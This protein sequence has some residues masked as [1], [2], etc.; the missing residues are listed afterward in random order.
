MMDTCIR[1]NREKSIYCFKLKR[2]MKYT[3]KCIECLLNEKTARSTVPPCPH[4]LVKGRCNDC[5]PHFWCEHGKSKYHCIR[6]NKH[7]VIKQNY[8]RLIKLALPNQKF[9]DLEDIL[10]CSVDDYIKHLERQFTDGMSWDSYGRGSNDWCIDHIIPTS[11]AHND[12][13][14]R[15]RLHY[16]NTRPLWFTN[17]IKK[18]N[19]ML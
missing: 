8:C 7:K 19:K 17:N 10:G 5:S 9:F 2:N 11:R 1:C 4:G 15:Y 13:E 6:C 12:D 16:F 14:I 18:G 3:K